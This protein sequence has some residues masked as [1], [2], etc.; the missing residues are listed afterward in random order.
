MNKD[1]ILLINGKKVDIPTFMVNYGVDSQDRA[2]ELAKLLVKKGRATVYSKTTKEDE[3]IEKLIH[4]EEFENVVSN[5]EQEEYAYKKAKRDTAKED[6]DLTN[7]RLSFKNSQEACSAEYWVNSLGIED[8]EVSIKQGKV[9]LVIKG[10][11]PKEY[12]KIANRYQ[13]DK[14]V[15]ST[16]AFAGKTFESTTDAINYGLTKVV[17]P[18]AKI[19]SEAGMNLGKGLLHTG[20]KVGAGLINSGSKAITETRVAMATDV[21]VIKAK[22]ELVDAKDS[23]LSFFR[24]KMGSAKRRSGI[25]EF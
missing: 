1:T 4:D 25:E 9:T 17:A 19:A 23:A 15:S 16:M 22:K 24:R 7:I 20:M 12:A 6:V 10:I 18:T 8:T 3:F 14:V 21:D 13:A 2:I 5:I 11:T